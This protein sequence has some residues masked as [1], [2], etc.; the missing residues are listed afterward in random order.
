MNRFTNIQSTLRKAFTAFA[1]V[2]ALSTLTAGN[3]A[4]K[5]ILL[6]DGMGGVPDIGTIPC[7]I[8]TQML[9]IGPLGTRHS[10]L[11]WAEGYLYAKT[12]RS[13]EELVSEANAAGAGWSFTALTDHF[14]SYCQEHPEAVTKSAVQDLAGK[15]T[16]RR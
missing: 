9:V 4:A 14:V 3:S 13:M 8:F 7:N 12:D 5:E 11:T 2:V 16:T 10:L 6:P 15:L 1:A